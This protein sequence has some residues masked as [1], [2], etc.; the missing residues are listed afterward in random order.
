MDVKKNQVLVGKERVFDQDLIYARVIGLLA[1]SREINF[2]NVLAFQLAAYPLFRISNI[3]FRC[4]NV[5]CYNLLNVPVFTYL[6]C[7]GFVA[8]TPLEGGT[9]FV[10]YI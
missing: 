9:Y 5:E 7:F 10:S 4:F 8:T 1:C 2:S 3:V 6:W